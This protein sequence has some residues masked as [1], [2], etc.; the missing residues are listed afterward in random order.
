MTDGERLVSRQSG[1]ANGAEQKRSKENQ[2]DEVAGL[3]VLTG[4]AWRILEQGVRATGIN[5]LTKVP[6][7]KQKTVGLANVTGEDKSALGY[8][9]PEEGIE[10][11]SRRKIL[12]WGG[13]IPNPRVR[14]NAGD[15]KLRDEPTFCTMMSIEHIQ[16]KL[17]EF[18]KGTQR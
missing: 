18:Q 9:N 17:Q 10:P 3:G 8:N 6:N 7:E 11:T 2:G 12:E 5:C 13:V 4:V 15:D 1:W 16:G 14:Y